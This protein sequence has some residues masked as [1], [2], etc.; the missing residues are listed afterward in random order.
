MTIGGAGNGNQE[1]VAIEPVVDR[2]FT[3]SYLCCTTVQDFHVNEAKQKLV[4]ANNWSKQTKVAFEAV[5]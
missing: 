5:L 3:G 1:D 4:Y 2:S